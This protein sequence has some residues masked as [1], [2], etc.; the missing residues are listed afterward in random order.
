MLTI[1]SSSRE[2]REQSLSRREDPPET[3]HTPLGT[4]PPATPYP[5][6]GHPPPEH[7]PIGYPPPGYRPPE[8]GGPPEPGKHSME[9]EAGPPQ[10]ESKGSKGSTVK[11]LAFN[12]LVVT[13]ATMVGASIIKAITGPSESS[14]PPAT[15]SDSQ[16]S[17]YQQTSTQSGPTQYGNGYQYQQGSYY[18][19]QRRGVDHDKRADFFGEPHSSHGL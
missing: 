4:P 11:S 15:S 2:V 18:Q 19:N 8:S 6:P 9:S 3:A 16:D 13:A 17:Q 1:F 5:P 10:K 12:F 14:S 7:P